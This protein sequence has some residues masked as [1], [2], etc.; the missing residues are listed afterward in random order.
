[1]TYPNVST[2]ANI[3]NG[4]ILY[5]ILFFVLHFS[6]WQDAAHHASLAEIRLQSN[7]VFSE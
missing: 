1:M 7:S 4:V 2:K 3:A 6:Y 5:M